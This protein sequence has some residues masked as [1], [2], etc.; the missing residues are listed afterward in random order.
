MQIPTEEQLNRLPE[1]V[2]KQEFHDAHDAIDVLAQNND[3]AETLV[4]IMS[5]KH[6]PFDTRS[7][8]GNGLTIGITIGLTIAEENQAK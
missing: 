4:I 6:N 3:M 7:A 2:N 1:I 8:F 5:K